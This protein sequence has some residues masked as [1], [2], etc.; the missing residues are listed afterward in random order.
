MKKSKYYST[1][2]VRAFILK[3][4]WKQNISK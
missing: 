3:N 2:V 1:R 4:K